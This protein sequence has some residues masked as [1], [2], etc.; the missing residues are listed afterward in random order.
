MTKEVKMYHKI[1]VAGYLG[2][3]PE[4]RYTPSGQPVTNFSV[5]T[6]RRWSGQDGQQH[7][8][9]VWWRV[10]VWGKQA[11]VCNQ[12]LAKGR[13]VLIE[14]R[15]GGDRVPQGDG[16]EQILPHIWQGQ[17]GQPRA[18][19]ELTAQTVRFLSGRGEMG[20]SEEA[21]EFEEPPAEPE[22]EIPF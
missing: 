14:G 5:A 13:A 3:D 22:E 8:E 7:N 18:R 21:D 19:F 2:R 16:S 15:V 20:P 1:I 17:D 4:M 11:E 6:S 9:T 10:T 12:Y